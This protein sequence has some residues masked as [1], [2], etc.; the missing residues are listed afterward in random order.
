MYL[1]CREDEESVVKFN[2][3]LRSYTLGL[4]GEGR[5]NQ[6]LSLGHERKYSPVKRG[7]LLVQYYDHDLDVLRYQGR[8]DS[9]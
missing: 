7:Y 8:P 2:G 9:S 6:T 4:R 5:E 1:S 3:R